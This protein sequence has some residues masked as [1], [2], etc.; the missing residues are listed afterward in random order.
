MAAAN[1]RADISEFDGECRLH[2][3]S[4]K[5]P[6]ECWH[7]GK[8]LPGSHVIVRA[9]VEWSSRVAINVQANIILRGDCQST[10]RAPLPRPPYF[11]QTIFRLDE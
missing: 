4:I 8:R 10:R 9:P 2:I 7:T 3:C 1:Q 6:L 5:S 11:T